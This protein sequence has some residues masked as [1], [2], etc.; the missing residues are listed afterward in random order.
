MVLVTVTLSKLCVCFQ[1]KTS[2][3]KG[4]LSPETENICQSTLTFRIFAFQWNGL[5]R[6][7]WV[8]TA[9]NVCCCLYVFKGYN[10]NFQMSIY[11]NTLKADLFCLQWWR[12]LLQRWDLFSSTWITMGIST[13]EL[14]ESY[15]RGV[16]YFRPVLWVRVLYFSYVHQLHSVTCL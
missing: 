3:A 4:L 15:S 7:L 2:Q 6:L 10:T 12:G 13:P 8:P 16:F 1:C 9:L 14:L 5:I 11:T